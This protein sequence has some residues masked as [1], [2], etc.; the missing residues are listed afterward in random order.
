[1]SSPAPVEPT[2]PAVSLVATDLDG[3]IVRTD[4]T[5]SAR[6]GKALR[7]V[8]ASGRFVVFVSGRPPRWLHEIADAVGHAGLAICANGALRYDLHTGEVS[9]PHYLSPETMSEIVDRMRAAIPDLIF[10]VEY[11]VEFACEPGYR[12]HLALGAPPI[13]G[14]IGEIIAKPAVKLLAR[15]AT[16][17]PDTL[18]AKAIA[19]AGEIA[20]FTHSTT[21]PDNALLEISLLGVTKA[22]G[23]AE[24]AAERGIDA[25]NV[26]AFGDM[27]ND[28]AM[29]DWAGRSVAVANAHP[30]VRA[31]VDEVA[32]TNDEDGVAAVLERLLAGD[33]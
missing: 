33:L 4:R 17:D 10:A 6:T 21:T 29:L 15:H 26:L 22:S 19:A 14:P 2:Q 16:L 8:E 30:S 18:M 11:G 25:A 23:L 32:A 20:T 3:T 7:A 27:P 5:I 31:A 1:M 24:F 13:V 28:L 12:H 9:A